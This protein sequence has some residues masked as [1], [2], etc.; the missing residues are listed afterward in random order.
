MCERCHCTS[1]SQLVS[2]AAICFTMVS[3]TTIGKLQAFVGGDDAMMVGIFEFLHLSVARRGNLIT[4]SVHVLTR[5]AHLP[6]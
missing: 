3:G 5:G 6:I 4:D 2:S 1:C